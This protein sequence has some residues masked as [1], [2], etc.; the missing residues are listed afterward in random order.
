MPHGCPGGEHAKFDVG[1]ENVNS[2]SSSSGF[3]LM[4]VVTFLYLL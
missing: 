3:E 1:E 4:G 2:S